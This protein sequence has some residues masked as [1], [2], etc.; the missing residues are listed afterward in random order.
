MKGIPEATYIIMKLG[1]GAIMAKFD[2]K[3]AY[4][5][6]PVTARVRRFFGIE[7]ECIIFHWLSITVWPPI[8]KRSADIFL[9]H[10]LQKVGPVSNLQ[11]YLDD[12]FVA[13]KLDSEECQFAFKRCFQIYKQLDVPLAIDNSVGPSTCITFLG[14]E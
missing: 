7:M 12:F 5:L 6:L 8:F 14:F 9:Q 3:R 11:H 10:I 13:G 4:R 2:I 1:K